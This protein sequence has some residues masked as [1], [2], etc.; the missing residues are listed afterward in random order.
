MI[1][2][3]NGPPGSG[4]DYLAKALKK[5]IYFCST[6]K[7]AE[8]IH[9]I[10]MAMLGINSTEYYKAY[11]ERKEEVVWYG[12]TPRQLV[13]Y[14]AQDVIKPKFGSDYFA[15]NA[16]K[17]VKGHVIFS[18]LGFKEELDAI[19]A[20]F[21]NVFVVQLEREGC[22]FA[23]DT[24]DYVNSGLPTLRLANNST[25]DA[26]IAEILYFINYTEEVSVKSRN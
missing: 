14:I 22:N 8:P 13:Q 10:A 9:K 18:D 4:K 21:Y 19:A 26:A 2:L 16:C 24:R 6:T 7:F 3:F 5:R 11:N 1:I 12:M 17:R 20:E 23:G 15:L 25:A